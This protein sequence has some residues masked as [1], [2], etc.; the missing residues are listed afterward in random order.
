MRKDI[1]KTLTPLIGFNANSSEHIQRSVFMLTVIV[2]LLCSVLPNPVFAADGDLDPTF[3]ND[4][5][6]IT[7]ISINNVDQDNGLYAIRAQPD[8]KLIAVGFVVGNSNHN[9]AVARYNA[10]G[11]L[12]STFGDGGIAITD[13]F[14]DQDFAL[15]VAIQ[16]DG[17]IVAVGYAYHSSASFDFALARYNSDGSLDSNFGSGGKVTTDFFVNDDEA[18]GIAILADGRIVV[19][20]LASDS[21]SIGSSVS[22]FAL[23]RYNVDGS[24][25]A[26]FGNGGKVTTDFLGSYDVAMGLSIQADGKIVTAGSCVTAVNVGYDFALARYNTDGTLDTG[27]GT[28]GKVTTDFSGTDDEVLGLAIQA[29]NKIVAVGGAPGGTG[30][31]FV[32][33]RYNTDGSLDT[34]FGSGGKVSTDFFGG[35]D[36]ATA[37]AIQTDQKIVV[38][39]GATVGITEP[40]GVGLARYNA[41]GGLDVSFGNSG[42]I[43]TSVPNGCVAN[44]LLIQAD[45]KIVVAGYAFDSEGADFVLARYLTNKAAARTTP[46]N[47]TA[48]LTIGS[49]IITI[50]YL[51]VTSAGFTIVSQI[52]PNVIGALP[53]TY[54]ILS[55]DLAFEIQTTATYSA[56]ITIAFQLPAVNDPAVFNTLR[57]LHSEDGVLVDRTILSPDSPAPDFATRT[58]YARVNS[59]SPFIVVKLRSAVDQLNALTTLV[60]SF[61]LQRGIEN[62][63]D[64]KLQNAQSALNSARAGDT[65]S[66]CNYMTSFVREVQAQTGRAITAEQAGQLITV[67]IQIKAILGCP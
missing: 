27:F 38:T 43:T 60:R 20:G 31:D 59:L 21:N 40:G 46:E 44:S 49:T 17:K 65:V 32:L 45:G 24:L 41:D 33:A 22:D 7:D 3:G 39:G 67:A 55:A 28:G 64:A 23:A 66:A 50:D 35:Y 16:N 12:D 9:F 15:G 47:P 58:I 6:V 30:D 1:M 34:T 4:G 61:N 29:D 54:E 2:L 48:E 57:I 53:N 14:G 18:L 8:G 19:A 37:V 52:D 13:F 10:D 51:D 11:S 63:L 26:T 36:R 5:V 25:D 56:P 42:K 62:S